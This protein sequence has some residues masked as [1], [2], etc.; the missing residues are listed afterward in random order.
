VSQFAVTA[1]NQNMI[2]GCGAVFAMSQK[3]SLDS[4]SSFMW[5]A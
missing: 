4:L 3:S 5:V 1:T 2:I